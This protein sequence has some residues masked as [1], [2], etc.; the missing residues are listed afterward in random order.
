MEVIAKR[1]F[2]TAQP[3]GRVRRG[4]RG[5][6]SSQLICHDGRLIVKNNCED[7]SAILG[8][9][10][11]SCKDMTYRLFLLLPLSTLSRTLFLFAV[12]RDATQIG[13]CSLSCLSFFPL[14]NNKE[15]SQTKNFR[16]TVCRQPSNPASNA[17]IS[18]AIAQLVWTTN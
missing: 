12:S 3:L 7:G 2:L 9:L 15:T 14:L 11:G 8:M 6:S 13:L 10:L 17:V 1:G 18:S 16:S 4:S 5:V